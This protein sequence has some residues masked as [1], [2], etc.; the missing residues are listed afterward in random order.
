MLTHGEGTHFEDG[1]LELD[2]RAALQKQDDA[3]GDENHHQPD[4]KG[5]PE[6]AA[7]DGRPVARLV[8]AHI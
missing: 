2:V 1:A 4:T 5:D 3:D 7:Q 8:P 6:L